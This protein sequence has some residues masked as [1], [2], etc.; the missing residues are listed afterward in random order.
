MKKKS[1][2]R[3]AKKKSVATWVPTC[4]RIADD[5][6]DL[7]GAIKR[8]EG[9]IDNHASIHREFEDD[10][11]TLRQWSDEV[12]KKHHVE[13]EKRIDNWHK[14]AIGNEVRVE[15]I[16]TELRRRPLERLRRWWRQV[17]SLRIRITRKGPQ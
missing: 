8:L 11:E 17:R 14:S 15:G 4:R 6:I 2:K 16:V 5:M 12:H 7:F 10:L 1:K 13:M 9:R 3:K